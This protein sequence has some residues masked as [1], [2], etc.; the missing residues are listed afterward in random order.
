MKCIVK[1]FLKD[2]QFLVNFYL[3]A[4]H[5]LLKN[6][7]KSIY[8]FSISF[9][10]I[11]EDFPPFYEILYRKNYKLIKIYYPMESQR[12]VFIYT[13][14]DLFSLMF[15]VPGAYIY[16]S[17]GNRILKYEKSRFQENEYE[18]KDKKFVINS[19]FS[20]NT[21]FKKYLA[22]NIDVKHL[23]LVDANEL[24][25]K[26]IE[27]LLEATKNN[28]CC[29]NVF[30]H[31]YVNG[32]NKI[33]TQ[34]YNSLLKQYDKVTIKKISFTCP[35]GTYDANITKKKQELKKSNEIDIHGTKW[36]TECSYN[37]NDHYGASL[38]NEDVKKLLDS[39]DFSSFIEYLKT[40]NFDKNIKSTHPN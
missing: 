19:T 21:D 2:D 27:D 10:V 9:R 36:Y 3:K 30:A 39:K 20:K 29:V 25:K 15:N 1:I 24:T 23:Y 38:D 26:Q 18:Y 22:D 37:C 16:G 31:K 17:D 35:C 11:L 14:F 4:C 8:S 6:C 12:F 7:Q 13:V 40:G 32:D 5:I 33:L 28:R 34:T